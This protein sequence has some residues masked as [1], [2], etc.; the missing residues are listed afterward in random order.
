M[1]DTERNRNLEILRGTEAKL[2]GA[3]KGIPRALVTWTPA[4]GKW[5]ILEIVGHLR[6]M[7]EQ[8]YLARYRRIQSEETPSLPDADGD[9]LSLE[10]DYRSQK[11]SGLLREWSRLRRESL[12]LLKKVKPA[13]WE[14]AGIHE[15]AGRLTMTHLVRRHAVGNDQAHLDQIE[16][17]QR[18]YA[19]LAR[20]EAAPSRLAT[21]LRAFSKES[22]SQQP[23]PD[24]WSAIEIACHLRDIDRLYTERVTKAAFSDRPAFWMMDNTLVSEK[25][26]YRTSEAAA[27]LKE[28]RRRRQDLL[29]LLRALPHESW[30][31]TGLH[32]TRGELTI[33]KLASVIA[34]HDDRHLAQIEA[35]QKS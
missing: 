22:L 17:I 19:V 26:A 23:A 12:K 28:H 33:E 6:D 2:K 3:L 1:D 10:N 32:P 4:P 21:A 34:D 31:R 11:L 14:R 13:E 5:S 18:R 8:A 16:A 35:L 25:L 29:S 24:K 7:E 30:Q 15:T 27:V 20:L 9:R